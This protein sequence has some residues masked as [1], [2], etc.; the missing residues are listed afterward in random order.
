M[1]I[2]PAC[3]LCNTCIA[4]AEAKRGYQ[5]PQNWSYKSLNATMWVLRIKSQSSER[6][7]NNLNC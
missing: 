4:P 2:L 7:A 5:I 3:T 6:A 1:Y